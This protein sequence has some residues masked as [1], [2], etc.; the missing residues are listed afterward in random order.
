[1][2]TMRACKTSLWV[3]VVSAGA[4]LGFAAGPV[5]AEEA[6]TSPPAATQPAT[7]P[8]SE[9]ATAA[10]ATGRETQEPTGAGDKKGEDRRRLFG[11][12]YED[13]T[14]RMLWQMLAAVIIVLVLGGA[15]IIVARKVLPKLARPSGKTISVIETVYLSPRKAV[16]LM[17]VHGR[18]LLVAST[19]ERISL[20]AD[21]TDG[22]AEENDEDVP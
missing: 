12:D 21:L 13:P 5:Q 8:A 10:A 14:G 16:H 19:R 1:M 3:V 7:E 18:R 20:L 2:Q 15:A 4:V 9:A 22:A 17:Q 6:P 11:E